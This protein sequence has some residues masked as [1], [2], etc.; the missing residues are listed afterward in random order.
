MKQ[1][2]FKRWLASMGATFTEGANHTNAHLNG[3][4]RPIP[5]RHGSKELDNNFI[6][7]ICKQLGL[8]KYPV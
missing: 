5:V 3:R 8:D 1:S 7:T 2:E 6:K 4:K